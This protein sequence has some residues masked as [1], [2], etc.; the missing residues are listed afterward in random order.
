LLTAICTGLRPGALLALH[1]DD[2]DLTKGVLTVRRALSDAGVPNHELADLLGHT[3]A[4]M[5]EVHYRHRLT[6][7]IDV[8][9][10]PMESILRD[11]D[12]S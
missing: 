8:A 5:V 10:G 11:E 7:T 6:E 3:T 12:R 1:W 4:R 2:V 9:V